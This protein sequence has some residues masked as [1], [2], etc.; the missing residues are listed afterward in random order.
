MRPK[1]SLYFARGKCPRCRRFHLKRRIWYA[2][3]TR[4]GSIA[5]HQSPCLDCGATITFS[6][7]KQNIYTEWMRNERP[8]VED[9]L[10]WEYMKN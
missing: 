3:A 1:Q 9:L 5:T 8:R 7:A 2:G 10:H 6:Q 4:D